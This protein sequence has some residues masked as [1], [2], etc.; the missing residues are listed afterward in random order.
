MQFGII[1]VYVCLSVCLSYR[2]YSYLS[3]STILRFSEA[4]IITVVKR[5]IML[6]GAYSPFY[7]RK[8]DTSS[9]VI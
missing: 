1:I 6:Y 2:I 4:S 3:S 7:A 5:Y 9:L 8:K